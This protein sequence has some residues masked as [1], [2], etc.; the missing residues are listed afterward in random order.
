MN[1]LIEVKESELLNTVLNGIV[2]T[3]EEYESWADGY[4]LSDAPE[5][6]MTTNI[7]REIW[8]IFGSDRSPNYHL[9][10]EES[11]DKF[12][13]NAEPVRSGRADIVLWQPGVPRTQEHGRAIIEVKK[14]ISR[15]HEDVEE[16]VCRICDVLKQNSKFQFGLMAYYTSHNDDICRQAMTEFIQGRVKHIETDAQNYVQERSMQSSNRLGK[17]TL[18]DGLEKDWPGTWAWAAGVMM[19]T[20]N[21]T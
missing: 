20:R 14:H 17:I 3:Q 8:T 1:E 11:V 2:R 7:A 9:T 5:Y 12:L 6:L 18:V 4:W 15:F 16:D 19:I 10:L 21:R 13:E